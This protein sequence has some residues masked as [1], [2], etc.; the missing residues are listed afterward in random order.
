MPSYLVTG[1][2]RGIGLG[3]VTKLLETPENFVVA[4]YSKDRLAV[5]RVDYSDHVSIERTAEAAA[6]LLPA[7][8][9]CLVSNAATSLQSTRRSTPSH[10]ESQR[11]AGLRGGAARERGASPK[12]SSTRMSLS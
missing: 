11:P 12:P 3:L 7:S 8:L 10:A 5:L 6:K 9:D 4:A 1:A 2:S